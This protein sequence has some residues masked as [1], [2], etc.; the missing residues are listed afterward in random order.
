MSPSTSTTRSRPRERHHLPLGRGPETFSKASPPRTRTLLVNRI[1]G[2]VVGG[3][4][5]S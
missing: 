1:T 5:A 4:T 3:G 2:T